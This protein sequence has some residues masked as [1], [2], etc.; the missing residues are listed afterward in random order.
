M[1][2]IDVWRE[3]VGI[4]GTW[5]DDTTDAADTARIIAEKS[6]SIT[7]SR[8]GVAQD[9]QT[10]RLEPVR[11]PMEVMGAGGDSQ[12]VDVVI[13]GYK[14]HASIDDTDLQVDDVF[15]VGTVVYRVKM[16]MTEYPYHLE[17]YAEAVL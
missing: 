12:R 14:N 4:G 10:V 2:N 15:K 5:A 7:V 6:T 13:L 16:L 3:D 1:P 8:A 11:Q 17:A 9:A